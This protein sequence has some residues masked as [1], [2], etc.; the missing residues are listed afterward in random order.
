MEGSVIPKPWRVK[1]ERNVSLG[2]IQFCCEIT[3]PVKVSCA[4]LMS[5]GLKTWFHWIEVL[6]PGW[7]R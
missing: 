1:L 2:M 3:L 7:C 4:T 5:V 6:I